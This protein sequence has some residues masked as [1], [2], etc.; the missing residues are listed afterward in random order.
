MNKISNLVGIL[1]SRNHFRT[2]D[3]GRSNDP[4]L[5]RSREGSLTKTLEVFDLCPFGVVG[6]RSNWLFENY[7]SS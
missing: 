5:R 4:L 2:P 3:T 7:L 6:V 1:N